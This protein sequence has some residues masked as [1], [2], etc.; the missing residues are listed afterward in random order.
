[1]RCKCYL[2]AM[3][4]TIVWALRK[5]MRLCAAQSISNARRFLK[6]IAAMPACQSLWGRAL[7]ASRAVR[8]TPAHQNKLVPGAPAKPYGIERVWGRA[9]K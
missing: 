4:R 3:S 7:S 5:E 9:V 8:L 1:V 6:L 2:T